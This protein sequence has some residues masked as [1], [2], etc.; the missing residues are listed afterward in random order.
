MNADPFTS[1]GL[2]PALAR[3]GNDIRYTKGG[4]GV[5]R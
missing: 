4:E 1:R 5:I 3:E 2:A